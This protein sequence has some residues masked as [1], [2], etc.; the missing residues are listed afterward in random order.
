M[1]LWFLRASCIINSTSSVVV[2]CSYAK[3]NNGPSIV[4]SPP[5]PRGHLLLI[6]SPT[7]DL[8]MRVRLLHFTKSETGKGATLIFFSIW[9]SRRHPQQRPMN[10]YV[11]VTLDCEFK[12]QNSQFAFVKSSLP[13]LCG[14]VVL[15]CF[16]TTAKRVHETPAPPP[17]PF[18]AN[19]NL[20]AL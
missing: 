3:P 20:H 16:S 6:I 1:S 9:G 13:M 19:S 7:I 5:G 18:D 14:G 12:M 10:I 8:I 11:I 17:P 4:T 15:L 2:V